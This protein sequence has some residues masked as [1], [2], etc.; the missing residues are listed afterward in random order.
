MMMLIVNHQIVHGN[1]NG[2]VR[3]KTEGTKMFAT[4]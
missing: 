3:K 4:P 2:G 1:P